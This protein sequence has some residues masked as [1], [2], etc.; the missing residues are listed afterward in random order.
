[1]KE[2]MGKKDGISTGDGEDGGEKEKEETK[3]N[4]G[5]RLD[6]PRRFARLGGQDETY[7]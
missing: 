5:G 4:K 7:E 3:G 1:M 6:C 2:R